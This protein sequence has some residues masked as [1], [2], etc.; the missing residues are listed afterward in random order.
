[1]STHVCDKQLSWEML[2]SQIIG[3]YGNTDGYFCGSCHKTFTTICT[4]HLHCVSHNEHGSYF[5]DSSMN[6]AYPKYGSHCQSSTGENINSERNLSSGCPV[7]ISNKEDTNNSGERHL[8]SD[9]DTVS[10]NVRLLSQTVDGSMVCE[11]DAKDTDLSDATAKII[12]DQLKMQNISLD[13]VI[14]MFFLIS[15]CHPR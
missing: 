4:L 5:Y 9:N 10:V 8:S 2:K 1:M 14:V 13:K 12:V 6:T 15:M 11:V 7:L 3:R